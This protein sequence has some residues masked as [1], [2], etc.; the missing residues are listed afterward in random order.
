MKLLSEYEPLAP[1]DRLPA[2]RAVPNRMRAAVRE[3]A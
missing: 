1:R 3:A 2:K